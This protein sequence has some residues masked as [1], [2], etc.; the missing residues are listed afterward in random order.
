M[1]VVFQFL[2]LMFPMRCAFQRFLLVNLVLSR[3]FYSY[4]NKMFTA[5]FFNL[6]ETMRVSMCVIKKKIITPYST[7]WIMETQIW[8][9]QQFLPWNRFTEMCKNWWYSTATAAADASC[10]WG[11]V[12]CCD[13]K[14]L[15]KRIST[16]KWRIWWKKYLHLIWVCMCCIDVFFSFSVRPF[17]LYTHKIMDYV[18]AYILP[19]LWFYLI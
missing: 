13:T 14:I 12:V 18:C 1:F 15:H 6:I 16:E 2:H 19:S 5:K 3:M 7:Q 11:L 4:Q 10:Y 17:L 8:L 9:A